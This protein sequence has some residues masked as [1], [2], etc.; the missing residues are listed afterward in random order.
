MGYLVGDGKAVNVTF[1]AGVGNHG[2]LYRIDG[3]TGFLINDVAVDDTAR[4]RAL[5]VAQ[6]RIWSI[7]LPSGQTP[8]VG[9]HL[10]WKQGVG[11]MQGDT[12]LVPVG[13]EA[14]GGGVD[15]GVVK[16]VAVKNT[17][18][19]AQ[20]MLTVQQSILAES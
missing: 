8:A 2:D 19:Y 15:P 11:F 16:V 14:Y 4:V 9:D 1:P 12:D 10:T 6:N 3:W 18:G 20:V 5:E 7:K 17:N 13:D